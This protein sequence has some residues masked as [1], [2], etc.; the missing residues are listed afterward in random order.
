MLIADVLKSK[1]AEVFSASPD[2]SVLS[3]AGQLLDRRV[4]ALVVVH[5]DAVVGIV[6]E[7][8]IVRVLAEA[9]AEGLRQPVL[10]CMTRDVILARPTETVDSILERMTDRRV[11]HIP[12]CAEGRL[13]GI[14]SIGDL[15]KTKIAETVA[16]AE[17]LR[18]YISAA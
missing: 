12:V 3:I 8:D 6:S 9:G 16:E 18:A 4:G 11:R 17:G 5:N 10:H 14:V 15:V 2:A 7:R 13:L 1:G